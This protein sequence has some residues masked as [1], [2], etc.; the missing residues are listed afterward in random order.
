MTGQGDLE[1]G[2]LRPEEAETLAVILAQA[3]HFPLDRSRWWIGW[4]GS[5]N[6]RVVRR[7]GQALGGLGFIR[8]GQWFG[9][10]RVPVAGVSAVGVAPEHRGQGVARRLLR[11]TLEELRAEGLPLSALYPST[12]PVYRAAGWE[13]AGAR[14][15]YELPL[16]AIPSNLGDRA[17]EV[18]VVPVEPSGR[19]ALTDLHLAR[20]R[21]TAGNLDRP[22]IF[23]ERLLDAPDR[24]AHAYLLRRDGRAEGYVV[25]TQAGRDDPLRILDYCLLTPEAGRRLLA[26]LAGYRSMVATVVWHGGPLDTLAALLPEQS[27]RVV[28]PLDWLLRIVDTELALAARGYP[29]G[30]TAEVHFDLRDDA[31]PANAGR[32][33]LA[34]ADGC[35]T[36]GR[37]GAGRIRLDVRALAA[38]YTGH[39]TPADLRPLGALAGP[40][41]DL[42]ALGLI[43]SGPRPW[44]P[45]GF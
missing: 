7:R 25:L 36:V 6:F 45:D 23:W 27:A 4:L 2:R 15:E 17:G 35:A 44:M 43:F 28:R 12:L 20:A 13:R 19:P 9:G 11:A 42:A 18:E 1:V 5:D 29:P 26:F 16:H 34:V 31:L 14:I 3:L 37:G 33:V 39:L 41:R 10:A 40:E 32:F 21:A 8:M 38:L 22:P 24:A 30:L